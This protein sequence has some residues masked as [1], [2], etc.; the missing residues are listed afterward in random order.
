MKALKPEENPAEVCRRI[1]RFR[2]G[3]MGEDPAAEERPRP[4]GLFVEDVRGE[5]MD[6]VKSPCRKGI[7]NVHP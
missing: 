6:C 3:S 7:G 5:S 2:R 4:E 1:V